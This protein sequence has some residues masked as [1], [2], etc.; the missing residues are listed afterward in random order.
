MHNRSNPSNTQSSLAVL[1][2]GVGKTTE[3]RDPLVAAVTLDLA[4]FLGGSLGGEKDGV[5]GEL[6]SGDVLKR[7]VLAEVV[8]HPLVE[9]CMD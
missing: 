7:R 1:L 3:A 8:V 2:L 9:V 4:A 6:L 5:V